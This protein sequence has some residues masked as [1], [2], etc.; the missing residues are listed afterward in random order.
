MLVTMPASVFL[1]NRPWRSG[2]AGTVWNGE[3]GITG[4]TRFEWR[5]APLRSLTSLGWAADWKGSGPDTDLGGR[6]LARFGHVVLDHVSGSASGALLQAV[7]SNLP[8]TCDFA[9]QVEMPRIVAGGSDQM[10]EGVVKTDP[11]TCMP[12]AGGTATAVPA[13]ILTAEHV[14]N[15]S[16]IQLAPAAQRRRV[17]LDATLGEDGTLSFQTTPDGARMLPFLGLPAGLRVQ[18]QL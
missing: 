14:G 3:V 12:K 2:I 5:W 8:F 18:G 15:T 7:Q 10:V 13:L 9:M 11:G 4:G 17:L 16:R 6:V 1:K